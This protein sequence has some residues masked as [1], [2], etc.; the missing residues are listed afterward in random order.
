MH[1]GTILVTLALSLFLAAY[2]SQPFQSDTKDSEAVIES[3]VA[4][5][6]KGKRGE[7]KARFCTQCGHKLGPEDRFCAHCGYPVEVPE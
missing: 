3:R 4:E 2:I 5:I 1:I 6:R 7:L